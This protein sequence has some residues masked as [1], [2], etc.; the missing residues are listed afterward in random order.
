MSATKVTEKTVPATPI[1]APDMVVSILRA[2]SELFTR[3][4]LV[5]PSLDTSITPSR[6]TRAIDN[7][8]D[9]PMMMTGTNQN[10]ALS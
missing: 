2:E 1:M 4:N 10:V 7:S 9:I 6:V 8:M 3:K 5:I